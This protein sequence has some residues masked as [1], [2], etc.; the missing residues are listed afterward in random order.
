M[1]AIIEL[2]SRWTMAAAAAGSLLTTVAGAASVQTSRPVSRPLCPGHGGTEVGPRDTELDQRC[3][4]LHLHFSLSDR[5]W[6][7]AA[8]QAKG[9]PESLLPLRRPHQDAAQ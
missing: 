1:T 9:R 8:A 7:P 3:G 4:L 6:N 2:L 5:G